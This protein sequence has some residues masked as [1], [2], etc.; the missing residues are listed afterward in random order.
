MGKSRKRKI[1]REKAS[2]TGLAGMGG[3]SKKSQRR[4]LVWI[5]G[6]GILVLVAVLGFDRW[7]ASQARGPFEELLS[8]GGGSLAQVQT[9]PSIS[10]DHLQPGQAQGYSSSFPTSG[11]HDPSPAAP[12][13]YDDPQRLENLVHS[14]EHG[15]IV[16]YYDEPGPEVVALLKDWSRLFQGHWD[17]FLA[18]PHRGLKQ[19]VVMTAW[20]RR[21]DLEPFDP[22][23]A[24]LFV[25]TYRGRGPEK[26]VR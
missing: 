19:K 17:G 2:G 1:S 10:R 15:H 6:L 5:A 20:R 14:I 4:G 26:T 3:G 12:G 22:A 21:L 7:R 24:A 16:V 25:D 18:V 13:F 11:A 23:S 8:A 9:T